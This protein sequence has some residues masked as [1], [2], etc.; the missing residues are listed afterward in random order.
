MV[1]SVQPFTSPFEVRT[2]VPS[3]QQTEK[4]WGGTY[5]WLLN[6]NVQLLWSHACNHSWSN[7]SFR[8]LRLSLQTNA[9][10]TEHSDCGARNQDGWLHLQTRLITRLEHIK[11]DFFFLPG[12]CNQIRTYD[13]Y[14]GWNQLEAV[15]GPQRRVLRVQLGSAA[16]PSLLLQHK[17][18][19]ISTL[20]KKKKKSTSTNHSVC[21]IPLWRTL[22]RAGIRVNI[23][24]MSGDRSDAQSVIHP[25]L[26][27]LSP[28]SPTN[29]FSLSLK[30]NSSPAQKRGTR[31]MQRLKFYTD[32][33]N[34]KGLLTAEKSR[35]IHRSL[36]EDFRWGVVAISPSVCVCVG[37]F[38]YY[39]ERIV[40]GNPFLP[41]RELLSPPCVQMMTMATKLRS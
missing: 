25:S 32:R 11:S 10:T 1:T 41:I 12:M 3:S 6:H 24:R 29:T 8:V 16:H 39:G 19:T 31:R 35:L 13:N 37:F 4:T 30:M 22:Y 2:H 23:R 40:V 21:L 17:W 15:C 27:S 20:C 36:Q 5:M 7:D 33:E 38:S 26:C 9:T 28:L 14:F 34:K 18:S